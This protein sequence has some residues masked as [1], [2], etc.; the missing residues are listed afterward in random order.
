MKLS[1]RKR[2]WN[3]CKRIETEIGI[4]Q[5]NCRVFVTG[6]GGGGLRT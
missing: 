6:S 2:R 4:T 1:N 5:E 3:F